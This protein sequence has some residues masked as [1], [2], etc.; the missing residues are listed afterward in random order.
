MLKLTAAPPT[1]GVLKHKL[2]IHATEGYRH[3]LAKKSSVRQLWIIAFFLLFYQNQ[4]W[5]FRI[6]EI[7]GVLL[8]HVAFCSTFYI[9]KGWFY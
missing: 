9:M 5:I 1:A 3:Y 2:R 4:F 6:D 8:S 7:L